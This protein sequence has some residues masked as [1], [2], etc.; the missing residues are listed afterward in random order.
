V[1]LQ[2][3]AFQVS[4]VVI[5]VKASEP[6]MVLAASPSKPNPYVTPENAGHKAQ[7]SDQGYRRG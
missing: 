5:S 7:R 4:V 3:F 1:K 6:E 2:K